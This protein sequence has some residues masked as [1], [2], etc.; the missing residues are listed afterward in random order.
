LLKA[1]LDAGL[2]WRN[3]PA[4]HYAP[5]LVRQ[6]TPHCNFADNPPRCTIWAG[7]GTVTQDDL[8]RFAIGHGEQLWS[9]ARPDRHRTDP[10][11]NLLKRLVHQ[12]LSYPAFSNQA[13]KLTGAAQPDGESRWSG[14]VARSAENAG[15]E[16]SIR[17]KESCQVLLVSSVTPSIVRRLRAGHRKYTLNLGS[18][19]RWLGHKR[20]T[21]APRLTTAGRGPERCRAELVSPGCCSPARC[22]PVVR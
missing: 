14:A 22:L 5:A 16:L 4:S 19:A 6:Q 8:G 17:L 13:A 15:G 11:D 18:G 7:H 2:S 10:L 9:A 20:E 3:T 21:S 12:Y 1:A